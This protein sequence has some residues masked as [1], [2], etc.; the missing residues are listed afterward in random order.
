V[1]AA[2]AASDEK[3]PELRELDVDLRPDIPVDRSDLFVRHDRR[4]GQFGSHLS[5]PM[6]SRDDGLDHR[7]VARRL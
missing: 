6:V 1:K 7:A 4:L 5:E 2:P 3:Q